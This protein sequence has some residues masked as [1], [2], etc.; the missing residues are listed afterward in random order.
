MTSN[1]TMLDKPLSSE[2]AMNQN[3]PSKTGLH[4]CPDQSGGDCRFP[5]CTCSQISGCY[6]EERNKI[7]VFQHKDKPHDNAFL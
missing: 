2:R 7:I 3:I 4:P 5:L 6:K 1:M